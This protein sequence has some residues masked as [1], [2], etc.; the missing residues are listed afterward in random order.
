M[1]MLSTAKLR[2]NDF[3][4]KE[5][6]IDTRLQAAIGDQVQHRRQLKQTVHKSSMACPAV[7]ADLCISADKRHENSAM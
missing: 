6:A 3:H 7:G 2:G 5:W 1:G 4:E